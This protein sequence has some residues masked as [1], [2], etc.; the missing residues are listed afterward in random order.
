VTITQRAV[1]VTAC[2]AATI[3]APIERVWALLV[4]PRAWNDWSGV[5][6]EA[7]EPDGP[8]H[9]GQRWRFAASAFGRSWPVHVTVTVTGITCEP[10]ERR[11]LDVDVATP[12]GIVNH[13][14]VTVSS[15]ADNNRGDE[16]NGANGGDGTDDRTY[17][18]FG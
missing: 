10:P 5:R 11:S 9:A 16:A 4:D 8:L 15:V 17:I 14:H 13:E 6:F 7:A 2:P 12:L 3:A 18:Q 1:T